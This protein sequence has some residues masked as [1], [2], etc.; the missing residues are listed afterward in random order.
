MAIVTTARTT[1]KSA[2]ECA[3]TVVR[4]LP[5]AIPTAPTNVAASQMAAR[6]ESGCGSGFP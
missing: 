1:I 5:T 2:G 3:N 6:R 4:S